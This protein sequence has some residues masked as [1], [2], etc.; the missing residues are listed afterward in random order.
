M[1]KDSN[2]NFYS[3]IDHLMLYLQTEV[4]LKV[5][6]LTGHC[7]NETLFLEMYSMIET[8]LGEHLRNR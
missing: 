4:V 5:V 1:K 8:V 2:L 3:P 6:F 7:L